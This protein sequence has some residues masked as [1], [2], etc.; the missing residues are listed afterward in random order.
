MNLIAPE[1]LKYKVDNHED[2][3]VIDIREKYETEIVSISAKNIPMAV[4]MESLDTLPKSKPVVFFCKSGSRAG[5]LVDMLETH[6]GFSNVYNLEG[7]IMGYIEKVAPSL[8]T[9]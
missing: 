2:I 4:V 3:E 5:A 8:P 6:Y 1:D 9:Y 7:G